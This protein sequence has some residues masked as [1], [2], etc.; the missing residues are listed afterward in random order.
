MQDFALMNK[1]ENVNMWQWCCYVIIPIKW[2]L[3]ESGEV[4]KC[5][6]FFSHLEF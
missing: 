5:P 1:N 6:F 2:E 4:L 3:D